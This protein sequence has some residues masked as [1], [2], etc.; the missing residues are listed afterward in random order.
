MTDNE[1]FELVLDIVSKI[2]ASSETE[3]EADKI[4]QLAKEILATRWAIHNQGS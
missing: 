1:L 3:N 4:M 2:S